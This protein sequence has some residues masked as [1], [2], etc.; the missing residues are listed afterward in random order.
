MAS[1]RVLTLLNIKSWQTKNL[2]DLPQIDE[3]CLSESLDEQTYI[4]D[5]G[6]LSPKIGNKT[7]MLSFTSPLSIVPEVLS[8]IVRLDKEI[9]CTLVAKEERNG[10]Y[11]QVTR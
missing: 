10:L 6:C 7:R 3:E 9:K 8:G 2:G 5:P 11:S 1:D 4:W